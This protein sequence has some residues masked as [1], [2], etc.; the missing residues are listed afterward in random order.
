MAPCDT[1][2]RIL[3]C[4]ELMFSSKGY[5]STSMR[6]LATKAGSIWPLPII[7]SAQKTSYCKR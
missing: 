4:A 1:K 6:A 5:G 7:T 2:N 3:D